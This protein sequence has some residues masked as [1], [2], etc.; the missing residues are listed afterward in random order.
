M[1]TL[2]E[3][4]AEEDRRRL[5]EARE[6]YWKEHSKRKIKQTRPRPTTQKEIG[7]HNQVGSGRD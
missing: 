2:K 7:T 3:M 5:S 4:N 1:A 6:D